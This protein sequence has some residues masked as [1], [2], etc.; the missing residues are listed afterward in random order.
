[1]HDAREDPNPDASPFEYFDRIFCINLDDRPDRWQR[2]QREFDRLGLGKRVE[3][4][5][6]IAHDDGA[7]GC[8]RSHVA[9]CRLAEAS[10]C[11]TVLV[12]EDDVELL[13]DAQRVL[14][15]AV[16]D[17][18]QRDA[19]EQFFLGGL[20]RTRARLVSPHLFGAEIVEMHAYA[21]HRR[22][23][24]KFQ[25]A[26][27]PIDIYCAE[28]LAQL[29]C[30]PLIAVQSEGHSDIERQHVERPWKSALRSGE[31]NLN[32]AQKATAQN[33]PIS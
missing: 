15:D 14:T 18:K 30:R 33:P 8:R 25:R 21:L 24:C 6:A 22:S 23:F 29:G 17:L 19:W 27:R 16:S 28:H 12:F 10:G 32:F 4:F 7:E 11:E 5:A 13:G 26:T 9:V 2:M 20:V 3:R 1:M 31:S